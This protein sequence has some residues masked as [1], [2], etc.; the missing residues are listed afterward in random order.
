MHLLTLVHSRHAVAHKTLAKF[1]ETPL[2]ESDSEYDAAVSKF[3]V[4]VCVCCVR[5]CVCV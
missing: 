2:A 3:T 1:D 4:C 5:V